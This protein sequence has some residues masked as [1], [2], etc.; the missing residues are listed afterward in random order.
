M[1][2]KAKA[3]DY[4]LHVKVK[5]DFGEK[6]DEKELDRFAR[7]GL[8]GFMKPQVVKKNRVEFVG[9]IGESIRERLKTPIGKREFLFIMEHLAV[10]I[11]KLKLNNNPLVGLALSVDHTYINKTTKEVQFLYVP[12]LKQ[13][14]E[15]TVL[16]YIET[17]IY[18]AHPVD[19]QTADC[20]MRFTY[21]V[22]NL[23]YYDADKVEKYIEKEDRSV[24]A[25]IKKQN[26]GQSGYMTD[27][28]MHYVE[29]YE[30][31]A[32]QEIQV[33]HAREP[34]NVQG[35]TYEEATG[36]LEE[37]ATGLLEEEATGLLA[38]EC[39]WKPYEDNETALLIDELVIQQPEVRYPSLTR[40]NTGEEVSINKPVFRI[41]K[42]SSYVDFFVSNNIN[43]SRSHA[44]IITRGSNYYVTDLNS[45]N[46]SYIN[47]Q[48]LTPQIETEICD[49]DTLKLANEDFIFRV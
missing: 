13:K 44:D 14:P 7:L 19:E 17:I 31:K 35:D 8:R 26:A 34:I 22:K 3:K 46:H 48:M 29:H 16:E 1:K 32:Q 38:D 2:Y 37:E 41:G 25:T 12:L 21:Y 18:S 20:L 6:I 15:Q 30:Q 33:Q 45:K 28:Q 11:Q 9:P 27:K 43:I 39:N 36:L 4:Y 49:G 47:G 23:P 24:V 40:M 10:A 42:E 5:T